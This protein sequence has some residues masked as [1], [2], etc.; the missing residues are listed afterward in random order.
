LFLKAA[1]CTREQGWEQTWA[2]LGVCLGWELC[3]FSGFGWEMGGRHGSCG[4]RAFVIT[5]GP[6]PA[7]S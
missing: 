4:L 7:S 6:L 1:C 2:E 5:G 3:V